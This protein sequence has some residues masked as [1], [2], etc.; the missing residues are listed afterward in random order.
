MLV[1]KK[2]VE[3][4]SVIFTIII[5]FKFV[6]LPDTL[7]FYLVVWN[8]QTWT[9]TWFVVT[10]TCVPINT[11]SLSLV[12]SKG[13][14]DG[15]TPSPRNV[16]NYIHLSDTYVAMEG[17]LRSLGRGRGQEAYASSQ[18][19]PSSIFWKTLFLHFHW[20]NVFWYLHWKKWKKTINDNPPRLWIRY[21][22]PISNFRT[23]M[24]LVREWGFRTHAPAEM[25]TF[26]QL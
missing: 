23:L 16:K 12:L 17:Q 1:F 20:K 10:S 4:E 11:S 21:I 22:Y 7:V 13:V 6:T 15:Q 25:S 18:V 9:I 24:L 8:R 14:S 5:D 2:K 26:L 19:L 3:G